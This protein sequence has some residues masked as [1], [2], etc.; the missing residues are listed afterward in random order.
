M[1]SVLDGYQA[2]LA[3]RGQLEMLPL[4]TLDL[5]R[6]SNYSAE[7]CSWLAPFQGQPSTAWLFCGPNPSMLHKPIIT[8]MRTTGCCS[9]KA[10]KAKIWDN[11]F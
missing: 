2:G 11:S 10:K 5:H 9:P 3:A 1:G 6:G 7:S 4:P 8:E